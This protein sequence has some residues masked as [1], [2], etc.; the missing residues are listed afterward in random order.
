M[1]VLLVDAHRL[2]GQCLAA[3]L[4]RKGAA[5]E[6]AQGNPPGPPDAEVVVLNA[7][8]APRDVAA[9]VSR[10]RALAPSARVVCLLPPGADLHDAETALHG[11]TVL[12]RGLPL[13]ELVAVVLDP[14]G[15]RPRPSAGQPAISA[16]PPLVGPLTPRERDVLQLLAAARSTTQIAAELGITVATARGHV[17][18]VISTLGVHTRLEA[19]AYA[20][21]HG[22]LAIEGWTGTG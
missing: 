13:R 16:A 8:T 20:A 18:S 6:V 5:V 10:L 2:S 22:L 15:R 1:Q 4:T 9:Q 7:R 11:T 21:R 3:A 17:Q 14:A 19:V 12:S